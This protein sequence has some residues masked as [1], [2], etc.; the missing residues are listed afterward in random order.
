MSKYYKC[1]KELDLPK[2]DGDGFD[3]GKVM[4]VKLKSVWNTPEEGYDCRIIGGEVRLESDK[5]GWIEISNESLK[6]CFLDEG[7]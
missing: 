1:I 4:R 7:A 6:E 5:Y 2:C 3:T